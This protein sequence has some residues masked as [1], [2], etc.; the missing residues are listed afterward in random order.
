MTHLWLPLLKHNRKRLG[1]DV[2]FGPLSTHTGHS[3]TLKA[4]VADV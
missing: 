3:D 1:L 2:W 4:K